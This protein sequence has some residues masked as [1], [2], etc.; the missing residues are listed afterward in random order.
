MYSDHAAW[1]A[2]QS[3]ADAD[4]DAEPGAESKVVHANG[5]Q[6]H[7]YGYRDYSGLDNGSGY[8]DIGEDDD[9]DIPLAQLIQRRKLRRSVA[10]AP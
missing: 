4:A 3:L 8:E 1:R 9:E 2:E 6:R 10:T 7:G 5:F